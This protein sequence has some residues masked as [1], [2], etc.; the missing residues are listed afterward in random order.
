L[1]AGDPVEVDQ[2]ALTG[3]S[4]PAARKPGEA[5][6]SGSIIRQGEI[7]AMVYA[8]GAKTYFGK[9]FLVNDRVKL[10]AYRIFDPVKAGS[11]P[12]V[13]RLLKVKLSRRHSAP[14]RCE[15]PS[16]PRNEERQDQANGAEHTC[17]GFLFSRKALRSTSTAE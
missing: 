5:V 6:F 8:T 9:T 14:R 12:T 16:E 3:E 13:K 17:K 7:G 11:A 10:L 2:S 1:L 15:P 4:L